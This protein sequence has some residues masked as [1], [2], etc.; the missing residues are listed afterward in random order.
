MRGEAPA[1]PVICVGEV[2]VD[3]FAEATDG[4]GCPIAEAERFRPLLG[5]APANAAVALARQGYPSA[6]LALVGDDGFGAYLR[7]ALD[8]EGVATALVDSS[9]ARTGLAF[10]SRDA[11]GERS[12]LFSRDGS[13]DMCLD[14]A[15][16]ALHAKEIAAAAAVHL[17]GNGLAVEPMA[18]ALQEAVA[19][20]AQHGVPISVDLNLRF[21]LWPSAEAAGAAARE[22]VAAA[23]VVKADLAEAEA[24]CG[25]REPRR[26]A[27][28]LCELG[29]NVACVTLGGDGAVFHAAG[30]AS[31]HV[32]APTVEVVDSTGAGDAFA[33]TLIGGLLA[34]EG[35]V[36]APIGEEE[37]SSLVRRACTAGARVCGH[38]GAITGLPTAEQL[39]ADTWP[40]RRP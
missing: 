30:G 15:Q 10:V 40:D 31:G 28:A 6:L 13:A 2:L 5:G 11:A 38:L 23:T 4:A 19:L 37:L 12:F 8:A 3:L 34:R 22:V 20:A 25:E 26:A 14:A 1:R 32:Q 27:R 17:C 9:P 29:P 33:A 16:V 7:R 24:V 39:D 36:A 18:S 35:G 21:H